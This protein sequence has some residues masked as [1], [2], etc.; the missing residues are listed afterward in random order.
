MRARKHGT[1]YFT[2]TF[3]VHL[4][5]VIYEEF[6]VRAARRRIADAFL[7]NL[8]GLAAASATAPALMSPASLQ[9]ALPDETLLA[10]VIMR[11]FR[12]FVKG[13]VARMR[14]RQLLF[15]A[16]VVRGTETT[17]WQS[18]FVCAFLMGK[19]TTLTQ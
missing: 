1:L 8:L 17:N 5:H 13:V 15:N 11:A 4:L 3:L 2:Y 16:K 6:N 10:A 14:R 9:D 7:A 18:E 19:W 12:N